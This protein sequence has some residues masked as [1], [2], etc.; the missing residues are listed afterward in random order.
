MAEKQEDRKYVLR[1]YVSERSPGTFVAVCLRPYLV[2]EG[3]SIGEARH[4]LQSLV[5]GYSLD[6]RKDNQLEYFMSRRASF[7]HYVRYSLGQIQSVAHAL[8]TVTP[9]TET[10]CVPQH[11]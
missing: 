8:N 7:R 4:R 5:Q 2:V 3:R 1:G 10:C 9:F 11:A 6:A